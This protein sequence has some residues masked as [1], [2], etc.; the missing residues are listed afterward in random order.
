MAD[1]TEGI[2][3][4]LTYMEAHLTEELEIR[5]IAKRAYLSPFYF[6]RVFTALCGVGVGEYIRSRRLTLAGEELAG[7]DAKVIDIAAKYGYESPD[8][9]NR[10]F[11]RFH[12]ICP[13]AARKSGASLRS[14]APM[15][16]KLTLE[17]GNMMEYKIVKK[18]QF[19]VM[20]VSRKFHPETSYQEIPEYW[21]EMMGKPGFPLMGMYGICID[22]NGADGEFDYWIAD[23]YIPWQEIPAGCES[24]VIASGTWAVFP[25]KLKTLQDTNTKM[26]QEWLP[27]CREYKLSGSYNVEMY[28]PLC[29][30]D[31]GD[32]Y[33]EL[34]LPVEK[35]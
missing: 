25:C 21:T 26:W 28:G 31:P 3:N 1:W 18:P 35:V 8:S 30:T 15:K 12:G 19:T 5:E 10:A 6:Q 13:S 17:G 24:L 9:F 11:Q 34:W 2:Q 14:F 4:A 7:T 29:E 27:S 22:G 33:V 16:I 23:N 32:S 20:G